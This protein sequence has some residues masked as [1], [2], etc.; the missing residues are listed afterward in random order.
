MSSSRTNAGQ[1]SGRVRLVLRAFYLSLLGLGLLM[2][3][4]CEPKLP[5]PTECELMSLQATQVRDAHQLRNPRVRQAVELLTH[6]CI[7]VPFD[8]EMLRCMEESGSLELCF[9][10]FMSRDPESARRFSLR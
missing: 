10:Q 3:W 6:Q 9:H 2:G 4:G 8:R 7:T 5:T 1:G